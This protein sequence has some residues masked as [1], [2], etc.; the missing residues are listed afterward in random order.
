M[1]TLKAMN[2]SSQYLGSLLVLQEEC[3]EQTRANVGW[4]VCPDPGKLS[5][6]KL[7]SLTA[8]PQPCRGSSTRYSFWGMSI[9]RD[10]F[11]QRT[12]SDT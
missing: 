6:A 1:D 2:N 10:S 8:I 3:F 12:T 5:C 7:A 9:T 4:A 11:H